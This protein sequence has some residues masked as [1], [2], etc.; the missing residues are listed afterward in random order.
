M[1]V[2]NSEHELRY[3]WWYSILSCLSNWRLTGRIKSGDVLNLVRR[4][5]ICSPSNHWERRALW[6]VVCLMGRAANRMGHSL[7]WNSSLI[8]MN[9][10]LNSVVEKKKRIYITPLTSISCFMCAVFFYI[11]LLL[12]YHKHSFSFLS[13]C[14]QNQYNAYNSFIYR[15]Q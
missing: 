6:A 7:M 2:M 14:I 9:Y 8:F 1:I 12:F 3:R 11:S 4:D 10:E 15:V 5:R 13:F